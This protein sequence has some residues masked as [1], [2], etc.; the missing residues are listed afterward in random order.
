MLGSQ[1]TR[2]WRE[3]QSHFR[4]TSHHSCRCGGEVWEAEGGSAPGFSTWPLREPACPC[5]LSQF[6]LLPNSVL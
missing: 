1:V 3:Q 4:T 5:L 2:G 6:P